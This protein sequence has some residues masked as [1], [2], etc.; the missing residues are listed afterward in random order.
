MYK[1]SLNNF[2]NIVDYYF[3]NY[4]LR[5]TILWSILSLSLNTPKG[6]NLSTHEFK[7]HMVFHELY[8]VLTLRILTWSS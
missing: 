2:A 5:D 4:Q 6:Y 8:S 1:Q 3:E 7:W